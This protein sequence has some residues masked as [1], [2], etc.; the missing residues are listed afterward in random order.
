MGKPFSC[1]LMNYDAER[2]TISEISQ[3]EKRKQE[4]DFLRTLSPSVEKK[5]SIEI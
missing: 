5:R 1:S 3:S 4:T 2:L